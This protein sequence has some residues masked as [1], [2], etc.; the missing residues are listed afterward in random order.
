MI[1]RPPRS[2]LFPYT[3]LFRSVQGAQA[4][5]QLPG[6]H[7]PGL[8]QARAAQQVDQLQQPGGAAHAFSVYYGNKASLSELSLY[9]IA[10]VEPGHGYDP[11]Q[12]RK[13]APGSELY[14]YASVA[15]VLP[16]RAYFS[17]IPEKSTAHSRSQR[18]SSRCVVS[19]LPQPGS[20]PWA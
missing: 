6:Q 5:V 9:D 12:F 13:Q 17:K 18:W 19:P 8:G 2:T 7:R 14:A 10:V 3:T 1:R 16:E 11:V 20:K 4:H 15:E